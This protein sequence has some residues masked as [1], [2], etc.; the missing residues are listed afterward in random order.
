MTVKEMVLYLNYHML[1]NYIR[2]YYEL[3]KKT[4]DYTQFD[5]LN[6]LITKIGTVFESEF[7]KIDNDY[8]DGLFKRILGMCEHAENVEEIK[9]SVNQ[10]AERYIKQSLLKLLDNKTDNDEIQV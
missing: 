1:L 5:K 4:C 9:Q 2:C 8:A 3:V 10:L 7:N 6:N